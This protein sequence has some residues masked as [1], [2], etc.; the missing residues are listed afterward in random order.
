MAKQKQ[1]NRSPTKTAQVF[2]GMTPYQR[3]VTGA[4]AL[5]RLITAPWFNRVIKMQDKSKRGYSANQ[6]T[7][8]AG[9]TGKGD[10]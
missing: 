5:Y 7:G 4:K 2:D 8:N 6:S 3:Q 10:T 1:Q 9:K